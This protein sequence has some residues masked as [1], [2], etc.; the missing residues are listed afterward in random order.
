LRAA[1]PKLDLS[2]LPWLNVA[3]VENRFE[4]Q[5]PVPNLHEFE[6][7]GSAWIHPKAIIEEGVQIRGFA[8]ISAGCFIASDAYLR[9]GVILGENT[10]VGSGVELKS[11]ICSGHS[12]FAHLNYVGNSI[13]G[14][15]VNFE[16]GS[17]VANHLNESVG[18][19]IKIIFK[20]ETID[21]EEP[22]F[23]ALVADSAKIGANSVLSPGTILSVGEIVPRLSLVNQTAA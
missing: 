11:V 15:G 20:G 16:A 1:F 23:G 21:T 9:G 8:I 4:A 12:D 14:S 6:L 17:I 7:I 18:T 19:T 3:N 5:P 10:H 2:V 13:I 22:K